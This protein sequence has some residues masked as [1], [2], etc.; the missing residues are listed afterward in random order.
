MKELTIQ[1]ATKDE[2]I[3][4]FFTPDGFRI[5][6]A[7]DSFLLWL[8]QKRDGELLDAIDTSIDASQKALHEYI[9]LVKQMNDEKDIDRKLEIAEKAEKAYERYEKAEK[10]CERYEKAEKAARR[11]P[12]KR[13]ERQ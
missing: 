5:P 4:Y 2:L 11:L 6:A 13:G 9:E 7:K 10:A 1:D 3:Q 12:T 8:K